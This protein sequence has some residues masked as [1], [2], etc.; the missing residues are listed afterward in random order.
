MEPIVFW[1]PV[2]FSLVTSETLLPWNAERGG[3]ITLLPATLAFLRPNEKFI[4]EGSTS[5][6]S[7][8]IHQRGIKRGLDTASDLNNGD[9]ASEKQSAPPV[10]H[11]RA[12]Q[13]T[14]TEA[15]EAV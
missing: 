15:T 5:E 12:P 3:A 10:T 13:R 7:L 9:N 4:T 8:I 6:L 2:T 14:D 1:S 11:F